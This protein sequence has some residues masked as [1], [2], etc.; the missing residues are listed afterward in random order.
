MKNS[1]IY[2]V[3]LILFASCDEDQEPIK[4]YNSIDIDITKN[5]LYIYDTKNSGDEEGGHIFVQAMHYSISE[6]VRDSTFRLVYRY[7][8]EKDYIGND[9]VQLE[10]SSGSNG[11]G[12]SAHFK[13]LTINFNIT[14]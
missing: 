3:I 10:L 5:E 13:Y 2:L 8:P 14:E 1:I 9:K 4:T 12:P 6:L 7:Q 11:A